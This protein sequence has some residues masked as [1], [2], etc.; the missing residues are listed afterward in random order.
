MS[1]ASSDGNWDFNEFEEADS[2]EAIPNL[3]SDNPKKAKKNK[4]DIR[5]KLEDRLE[6]KRLEDRIGKLDDD[7]FD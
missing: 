1:G 4:L 7:W 2:Y 6:R 3:E 5:R